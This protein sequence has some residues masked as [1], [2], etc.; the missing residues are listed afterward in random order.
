VI[1][2]CCS[3]PLDGR[4]VDSAY[5]EEAAAAKAAGFERLLIDYEAL[6]NDGD[7][8]RAVRRVHSQA[9]A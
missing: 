2:V 4:G 6:V 9:P 5:T 7:A 8:A 1:G 3:D